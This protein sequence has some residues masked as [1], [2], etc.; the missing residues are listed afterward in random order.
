MLDVHRVHLL[1]GAFDGPLLLNALYDF[2]E[3][4]MISDSKSKTLE[5]KLI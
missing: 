3:E 2:L 5:I 4:D 1:C